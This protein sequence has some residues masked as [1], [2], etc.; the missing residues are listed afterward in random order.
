MVK[1]SF[2]RFDDEVERLL[3]LPILKEIYTFESKKSAGPWAGRRDIRNCTWTEAQ[4]ITHLDAR[5]PNFNKNNLKKLISKLIVDRHLLKI[6]NP[7]PSFDYENGNKNFRSRGGPVYISRMAEIVRTTGSLH[8]FPTPS[9]DNLKTHLQLI[10]GTKWEPRLRTGAPRIIK[11]E[12]IIIKM[13]TSF[14]EKYFLP[15]GSSLED[16]LTDLK[17][18]LDTLDLEFGGNL[19]FSDF[20]VKSIH[21]ALLNTWS[22]DPP[23]DGIIITANTGAGKTLGFVI[24]AIVDALIENRMNYHNKSSNNAINTLKSNLSQLILYPRNDLAKDQFSTIEEYL[25]L[26]NDV[27]INTNRQDHIIT[28]GIDAG[29]LIQLETPSIPSKKHDISWGACIGKPNVFEAS[30]QKYAGIKIGRPANIMIASIESFRRRMVNHNVV[31]HLNENLKRV[32][33]DEIHLSSGT[34]G[35]HHSYMLKRLQQIC[36]EFGKK[37]KITFI[38]ASATIAKPKEHTAIIWQTHADKIK[39]IHSEDIVGTKEPSGIMN[40]LFVRTKKGA[41]MVGSLVDMTSAIGHQR[42]NKDFYDRPK[43]YEKIQKSIGFADSHDVVGNWHQLMLENERTDRKGIIDDPNSNNI[44]LPYS[45]WFSKPLEIHPGGKKVCE[46][47]QK[48]EKTIDPIIIKY[49]DINKISINPTQNLANADVFQMLVSESNNSENIEQIEVYGLD[50]CPHLQS[51]TCWWFSPRTSETEKRPG[52]LKTNSYRDVLRVKKHTS[53]SKEIGNDTE[54]SAN[55]TFRGQ[56]RKGAYPQG[57]IDGDNGVCAHDLVIATP[58]LEV[59]IDMDNVTEVFTHKAIRNISSYRQ[60]IGRG[61]REIGTDA[62]SATLMSYRASDFLHYRSTSRLIDRNILEPVPLANDNQSIQKTEAYMAI[63]DWFAKKSIEIEHIPKGKPSFNGKEAKNWRVWSNNIKKALKN[64]E[65]NR[66]KIIIYID[67]ALNKKLGKNYIEEAV[68]QTEE[69]LKALLLPYPCDYDDKMTIADWITWINSA[70]TPNPEPITDELSQKKKELEDES[71]SIINLINS[72][73]NDEPGFSDQFPYIKKFYKFLSN[74]QLTDAI[75]LFENIKNENIKIEQMYE[76][77]KINGQTRT[78]IRTIKKLKNKFDNIPEIIEDIND[79]SYAESGESYELVSEIKRLHPRRDTTYLSGLLI[80]C[81]YFQKTAPYVMLGTL[82]ANPYESII[83]LKRDTMTYHGI[84][85]QSTAKDAL[86]YYLPGMWTFRAFDGQSLR[87]KSGYLDGDPQEW[88]EHYET[89]ARTSPQIE[90]RGTMNMD[91]LNLIPHSLRADLD[92]EHNNPILMKLKEVYLEDERGFNNNLQLVKLDVDS[93]LVQ[94]YDVPGGGHTKPSRRPNSFS[95]TWDIAELENKKEIRSYEISE[96]NEGPSTFKVINHPLMNKIFDSINFGDIK[97]KRLASCVART[98]GHRIRFRY[99]GKSAL[100]VDDFNTQGIEFTV[101]SKIIKEMK[102]DSDE[103]RKLDYD[104]MVLRAFRVVMEQ[105]GIEW[106]KRYALDYYIECLNQLV[107]K[108]EYKNSPEDKFPNSFGEFIEIISNMPLN[109]DIIS[110]RANA[111]I[112]DKQR[113][114]IIED[115]N[116]IALFFINNNEKIISNLPNIIFGWMRETYCNTLSLLI[117]DSAASYAGVPA[118]DISYSFSQKDNI[119]KIQIYD[120]DANGNGTMDV[121]NRFF[122]IPKEVR[123]A[124]EHFRQGSLPSDDFIQFLERRLVVCPEHIAQTIAIESRVNAMLPQDLIDESKQLI[125][126]YKSSSWD[127][128]DIKSVKD[129]A[130]TNLRRFFEINDEDPFS[131]LDFHRQSLELCDSGCSA[132]NGEVMLN[133]YRGHLSEQFT[134]RSLV[135]KYIQLGPKIDGYLLKIKDE[136]ELANLA[137]NQLNPKIELV[138]NPK[139]GSTPSAKVLVHFPTP[140]IGIYWERGKEN[141]NPDWIV[142]HREAI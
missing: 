127:K 7:L 41:P 18:V 94:G 57:W 132:C 110:E 50:T 66:S 55:H 122:Q 93:G 102:Q 46:S 19:L 47:C 73:N 60:K 112:G 72:Q 63:F 31:K 126:N 113:D 26:I 84:S 42:R 106:N 130:L 128:F 80:G 51:G 121:I 38:G 114:E 1:D 8:S 83:N 77:R 15:N 9:K 32:I 115:I 28:I 78:E 87:V 48:M 75:E 69:H 107:Y 52:P 108:S 33:L 29:G 40:H 13:K 39:H 54:K 14:E 37:Q 20:Q 123:D 90:N 24:P 131:T 27:L 53:K 49:D 142:R 141:N 36:Y 119:W 138:F 62:V 21:A 45:N 34:Q 76:E 10:E 64:I 59:G 35:A 5:I 17:I 68:K 117:Q 97:V 96:M 86:R 101:N 81:R 91:D 95:T 129:A 140:P 30:N 22:D 109:S 137:G 74:N 104:T 120:E 133:A 125:N 58:T 136:E 124:S 67:F 16:A 100:Y 99:N 85:E 103:W 65:D 23:N 111:S 56:P 4:M 79:D 44:N 43:R 12:A 25:K 3:Y 139:D 105:S 2:I 135:D 71:K 116:E 89:L 82:F 6:E 98:T 11:P 134:S 92:K 118:D 88:V 70:G 61:G